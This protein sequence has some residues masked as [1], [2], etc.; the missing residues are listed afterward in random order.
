MVRRASVVVCVLTYTFLDPA[1]L[2]LAVKKILS[3]RN[4]S[5]KAKIIKKNI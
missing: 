1:H 4:K 2:S 3:Y 5:K